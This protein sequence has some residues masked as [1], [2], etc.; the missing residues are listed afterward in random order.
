MQNEAINFTIAL[1]SG[2][3][4]HEI[5]VDP[6]KLYKIKTHALKN[7]HGCERLHGY[8]DVRIRQCKQYY[9]VSNICIR[10]NKLPEPIDG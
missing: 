2:D 1:K 3:T 5:S 7:E 6:I 9:K 10:V 8:Y 4:T